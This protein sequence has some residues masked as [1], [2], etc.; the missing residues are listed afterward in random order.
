MVTTIVVVWLQS[1]QSLSL[2]NWTDNSL[3]KFF[4]IIKFC[5]CVKNLRE[6]VF[7]ISLITFTLLS[8]PLSSKTKAKKIL[9][10]ELFP[11]KERS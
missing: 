11:C 7:L 5:A 3:I 4:T 8:Q 10:E 9:L 6:Y 1:N 2:C